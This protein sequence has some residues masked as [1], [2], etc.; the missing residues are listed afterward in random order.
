MHLLKLRNLTL[1]ITQCDFY[2]NGGQHIKM[3]KVKPKAPITEDCNIFMHK[4]KL[5]EGLSDGLLLLDSH[6]I[7]ITECDFIRNKGHGVTVKSTG[8]LK[9]Q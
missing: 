5:L 4:C 3:E 1:D 8:A 2:C 7:S 9:R 6:S